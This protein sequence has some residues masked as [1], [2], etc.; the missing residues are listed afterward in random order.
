[1]ER[2]LTISISAL[3]AILSVLFYFQTYHQNC[4]HLVYWQFIKLRKNSAINIKDRIMS[5]KL[6]S[7]ELRPCYKKHI[8]NHTCF[9]RLK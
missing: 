2:R 5:T 3:A 4:D 6:S 1:M 9:P 8:Q 7:L